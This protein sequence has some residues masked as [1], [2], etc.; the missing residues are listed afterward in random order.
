[1]QPLQTRLLSL[2]QNGETI[3]L[4]ISVFFNFG[5]KPPSMPQLWGHYKFHIVSHFHNV[6]LGAYAKFHAN[7]SSF[8][9]RKKKKIIFP[10]FRKLSVWTNMPERRSG[11]TTPIY[12]QNIYIFRDVCYYFK[13]SASGWM[14]CGQMLFDLYLKN[15]YKFQNEILY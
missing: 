14:S 1:M 9:K 15:L 10:R 2:F 3:L 11:P 13:M 8:K 6:V 12:Y 7:R 5:F 4:E